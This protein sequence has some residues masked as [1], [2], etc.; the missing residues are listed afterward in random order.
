MSLGWQKAFSASSWLEHPGKTGLPDQQYPIPWNDRPQSWDLG[1]ESCNV[2][3]V[4]PCNVTVAEQARLAVRQDFLC[5]GFILVRDRRRNQGNRPSVCVKLRELG[6][7]V[8]KKKKSQA[9]SRCSSTVLYLF[10]WH[11]Y[12]AQPYWQYTWTMMILECAHISPTKGNSL[13]LYPAPVL[14][15]LF[16]QGGG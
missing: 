9:P 7:M 16:Q 10:L 11:L 1:A 8:R 2:N 5:S 13:S 6:N 4:S 14:P 3:R 15:G 12:P